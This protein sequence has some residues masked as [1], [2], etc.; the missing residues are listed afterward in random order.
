MQ[1]SEREEQARH[2]PFRRGFADPLDPRLE[3]PLGRARA[4][5]KITEAEYLAGV[6]WRDVFLTYLQSIGAPYPFCQS[7]DG[8]GV[9]TGDPEELSD[10]TCERAAE[11]Y[12]RGV[13]IL[14]ERGRR[15]Y[16]AVNAVAVYEESE[17]L[18]D[19]EQT[20]RSARIGL[21]ELSKRF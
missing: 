6:K 21:S 4:R 18:G 9:V 16:H 3:C 2:N 5:N 19:H 14:M 8:G 1:P 15:V 17:E 7:V 10:E 13:S 12:K 20:L 11:L